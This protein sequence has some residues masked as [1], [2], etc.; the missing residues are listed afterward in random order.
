MQK[1]CKW[2]VEGIS[3]QGIIKIKNEELGEF[4]EI[5]W[6][7]IKKS[8]I[9]NK[10]TI[11]STLI[12]KNGIYYLKSRKLPIFFMGVITAAACFGGGYLLNNK[13]DDVRFNR[14][15]EDVVVEETNTD[16][17]KTRFRFNTTITVKKNTIQ[18]FDFENVNKDKTL[19]VKI[20]Y[21]DEY[22]FD[23]HS[24]AYGKKLTADVLTKEMN[25]GTYN[26]IA[27]VYSYN[28]DGEKTN[29]TNFQIKIIVE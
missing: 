7:D 23:S 25:K 18:N 5:G 19:Q 24:I 13:E 20:R 29:Q 15:V 26:A 8:R 21:I 28:M 14:Y 6:S 12:E 2:I 9:K 27:E 1:R 16:M 11:H 3:S 17:S 10:L 22:I 4:R